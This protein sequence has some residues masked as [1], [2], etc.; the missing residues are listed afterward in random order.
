MAGE[1]GCNQATVMEDMEQHI[2][3]PTIVIIL[4]TETTPPTVTTGTMEIMEV[5]GIMEA[6][7]QIMVHS[8]KR[9]QYLLAIQHNSQHMRIMVSMEVMDLENTENI[10][11]FKLII[12]KTASFL[13]LFILSF[14]SPSLLY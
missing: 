8:S 7:P 4:L 5:M 12:L 3:V 11:R 14:T 6:I 13:C 2:Q 9:Y 10:N 1:L